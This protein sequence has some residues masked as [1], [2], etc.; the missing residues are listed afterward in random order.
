[1]DLYLDQTLVFRKVV[2]T[3][4]LAPVAPATPGP[5]GAQ[6]PSLDAVVDVV[7]PSG[8]ECRLR[9]IDTGFENTVRAS[10][11]I[12]LPV[13]RYV[14]VL[15]GLDGRLFRKRE[16][17]LGPGADVSLNLAE[18]QESLPHVS[19]A[20]RLPRR[21]GGV[22]FSESLGGAVADTDLDLWL[23]L[24]GGGRILGS[25]GDYSKLAGFPL[26]DFGAEKPGASPLYVLAGLEDPRAALW[27]G[28][29]RGPDVKWYPAMPVSGMPGIFEAYQPLQPGSY[30]MSLRIGGNAPYTVSTATIPN[31]AT[32][33]TVTLEDDDS[34]RITQFLLPLGH[35][36]EHLPGP[37]PGFLQYRN[38]LNDVRFIA[39]ASRAFRKRRSL[40]KALHSS[41]LDELLY[42]KWLDPIGS[43]LGA[44]ELLRRGN[45]S[46]S[47]VVRNMKEYFPEFPDTWA[48]AR[49]YGESIPGPRGLPLFL[50]GLRAFPEAMGMLPLPAGHLDYTSPWTAWRAAVNVA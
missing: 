12:S 37:V 23:A 3:G 4:T 34:F 32:L 48:L 42:A 35:L 19:I 14:A 5:A 6:A 16:L 21:N 30:L 33:V 29:S 46:M 47:E 9:N 38:H 10:G 17:D 24:L 27:V 20:N 11:K 40:E 26:H 50:D 18:W 13:G 1:V 49:L 31:R 7:V 22:D 15:Q 44:Y 28:V 39:Q 25:Q 43:S 45:R 36:I 8:G 41:E 2:P